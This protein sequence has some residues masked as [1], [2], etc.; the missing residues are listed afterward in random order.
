[1]NRVTA[2]IGLGSN[3]QDPVRQLGNAVELL[4]QQPGI[5][6]LQAS[7]FYGSAPVGDEYQGQPDYVNAVAAILTS[8]PAATLLQ[9]LLEIELRCGRSRA[10]AHAARTLDLDLLLYGQD[11]ISG[12]GLIVPH[13]RMHERAFVLEPLFE[14]APSAVI[15]GRGAVAELREMCHHQRLSR[16][17]IA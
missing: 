17:E 1:M 16:L 6:L 2:Y 14:I 3:L 5:E 12:P 9:R 13:P 10:R 15:P 8:L 11:T 4:A 7:S